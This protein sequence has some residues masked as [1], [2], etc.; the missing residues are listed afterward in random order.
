MSLPF[1]V[2]KL[3]RKKSETFFLDQSQS[4]AKIQTMARKH[5][6][7]NKVQNFVLLVQGGPTSALLWATF[8]NYSSLRAQL[9]KNTYFRPK[10]RVFSKKKKGLQLKSISKIPILVPKS[11]CSLKKKKK[12]STIGIDLRSSFFVPKS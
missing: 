5:T 12:R 6:H 11:G 4:R 10:I 3:S 1:L 2:Y 7:S 8:K 9:A